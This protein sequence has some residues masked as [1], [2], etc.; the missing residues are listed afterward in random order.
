MDGIV[1]ILVF[2]A[3]AAL[4]LFVMSKLLGKKQIAQLDVIDYMLGIAV[5]S[6]AAEWAI[7]S[8]N[9]PFYHYLT[10]MT[11]FFAINLL[12]IYLERKGRRLKKFIKGEPLMV[13]Y[14]GKVNYKALKKSKMDVNDMMAKAREKGYFDLGKIEY[15]VFEN[16]GS[17]SIMP[18]SHEK[19]KSPALPFYLVDDG[20]IIH[21]SLRTLG[22]DQDWL[23]EK[24]DIKHKK[25]LKN[26]I[27][28]IYDKDTDQVNISTKGQSWQISLNLVS[29][30]MKGIRIISQYHNRLVSVDREDIVIVN[31]QLLATKRNGMYVS[32]GQSQEF[33]FDVHERTSVVPFGKWLTEYGHS[34]E[35]V[36]GGSHNSKFFFGDAFENMNMFVQNILEKSIPQDESEQ[37]AD[38]MEPQD[39]RMDNLL[40]ELHE[41]LIEEYAT[42]TGIEDLYARGKKIIAIQ[43]VVDK[44]MKQ[45]DYQ[46][47]EKNMLLTSM[48]SSHD[49]SRGLKPSVQSRDINNEQ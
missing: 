40:Q 22:K 33:S 16:S 17:L 9:A 24:L 21:S 48:R 6:I 36:P 27:L 45:N 25:E 20:L 43:N 1:K 49:R 3:S 23:F 13:I 37:Q 42:P 12:I 2:S 14:E 30:D 19:P 34:Y 18:K 7:D 28:A 4:Y 11:F 41:K 35:D 44:L 47:A 5:S 26:I 15:A 10:A 29:F 39:R 31:R 8:G 38:E 32:L 46:I